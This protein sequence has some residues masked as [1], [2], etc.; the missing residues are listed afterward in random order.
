METKI[1]PTKYYSIRQSA[2]LLPWINCE[3]TLHKLVKQ[4]IETNNNKKFKVISIKREKMKRCFIKG[5]T[6]L[7][8]LNND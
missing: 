8:L 2:K 1:D 5:E 7:G 4:D 6:L 3:P